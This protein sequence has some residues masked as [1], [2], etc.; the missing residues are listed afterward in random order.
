MNGPRLLDKKLVNTELA[1]QRKQQI[2][3]GLKLAQKVDVLRETSHLEAANLEKFRVE[4]IKKV[5]EEIDA[6]VKERDSLEKGNV[7]LREERI[8][9]SAPID[10]TEAREKVRTDRLELDTRSEKMVIEENNLIAREATIDSQEKEY[11][12]R[13]LNLSKMEET[14]ER[15]LIEAESKY[16]LA[17]QTLDRANETADALNLA[18]KKRENDVAVREQDV[19]YFEKDLEKR[20]TELAALEADIAGRELKLRNRQEI[21][22][23]AQNYIKNKK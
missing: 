19:A 15:T 8:V 4:T 7:S 17:S 21:F 2:D 18:S 23:R 14:T 5:Q 16:E 3:Q 11:Q 1:S 20:E 10:L 22:M 12:K 6:K 13:L 9:L